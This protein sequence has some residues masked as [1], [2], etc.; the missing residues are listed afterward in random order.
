MYIYLASPYSHTD[1]VIRQDRFEQAEKMTVDL[2]NRNLNI[3]CPIVYCHELA[4]RYAIDSTFD[5]WREF[6][7]TMLRFASELYVL[8]IPGI[9]D[10]EGVQAEVA[11]ARQCGMTIMFVS[12]NSQG[13]V[14]FHS[15]NF[16]R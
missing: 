15:P 4:N 6:N 16:K 2:I 8:D 10:S 7:F 9:A 3:F 14:E 1:S 11:F 13:V 5:R 12:W